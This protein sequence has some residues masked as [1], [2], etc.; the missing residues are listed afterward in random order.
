MHTWKRLLT[1]V[2]GA[3][4]GASV[5]VSGAVIAPP[6]AGAA[7]LG[8]VSATVTL[9]GAA[10]SGVCLSAQ[11]KKSSFTT[12]PSDLAGAI[13]Q[14]N[15]TAGSYTGYY[16][17]CGG[18]GTGGV[19][20]SFKVSGGKTTMLGAQSLPTGG[21]LYGQLQDAN[22]GQGAPEVSMLAVDRR[23]VPP[24]ACRVHRLERQLRPRWPTHEHRRQGRIRD[25]WLLQRRN[26]SAAVVR[27]D[28]SGERHP[29]THRR[30]L[31]RDSAD[32]GD[33][34]RFDQHEGDRHLGGDHRCL[35]P[36]GPSNP[37]IT[38]TGT[39][40]GGK[41]PKSQPV[42]SCPGDPATG[43]GVNFLKAQL[44]LNDYSSQNWQAGFYPGDC[45]GFNIVSYSKTQIVFTFGSWYQAPGGGGVGPTGDALAI[46]D[47]YTMTVK[48]AHF[49]GIVP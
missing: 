30:R 3:A 40:F 28:E 22:L 43:L 47:V 24:S 10:V 9:S 1:A 14:A 49:T 29:G 8:T 12:A 35:H 15:V 41:P 39:G 45:I 23:L 38:V 33:A 13:T 20:V 42:P 7:G 11:S 21:S 44:Y 27:R 16:S 6:V 36:R 18:S 4:I 26:L 17:D 19:A 25:R 34:D 5:L 32:H 37:T 2:A 46:G 48:G 31:L